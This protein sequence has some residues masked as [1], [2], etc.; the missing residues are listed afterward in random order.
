M[1]TVTQSVS[2]DEFLKLFTAQLKYQD[3]LNPLESKEFTAQ[4]AQFS[5]LEQ[6]ININN[7]FDKLVESQSNLNQIF[8][9]NLIGKYV[10]HKGNRV[11]YRGSPVE[12]SYELG[13]KVRSAEINI[14]SE[15]GKLVRSIELGSLSEGKRSYIWDGTD[16]NG[17]NVKNGIYK[18]EV[19]T[20]KQ[21]GESETVPIEVM[22]LV[23]GVDYS[24][25]TIKLILDNN[26]RVTLSEIQTIKEGGV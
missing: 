9:S 26:S 5:S 17:F 21:N 11:V 8:S 16:N 13:E 2:R 1:N 20:V 22:S 18:I 6:L 3:P 19:V 12:F 4:L 15:N 24:D 10:Q 7:N 25:N 14:Y 23:T